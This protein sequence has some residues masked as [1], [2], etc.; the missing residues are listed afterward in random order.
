MNGTSKTLPRCA[1]LLIGFFSS[2]CARSSSSQQQQQHLAW[3]W[4]SHGRKYILCKSYTPAHTHKKN[5]NTQGQLSFGK[6]NKLWVP[7]LVD[8]EEC[9]RMHRLLLG[10]SLSARSTQPVERAFQSGPPPIPPAPRRSGRP[11][12]R[13]GPTSWAALEVRT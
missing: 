10:L 3:H 1:R 13:S 11:P 2:R 6:N 4:Y 9:W 12:W 7:N 5:L 8:V